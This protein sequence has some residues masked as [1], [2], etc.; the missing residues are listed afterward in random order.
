MI[1]ETESLVLDMEYNH[2]DNEAGTLLKQNARN[3]FQ[4]N[5]NLKIRSNITKDEKNALKS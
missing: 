3:I 4:K 2:K 5:L 1:R